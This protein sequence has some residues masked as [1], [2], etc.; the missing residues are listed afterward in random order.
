MRLFAT[1]TLATLLFLISFSALRAEE[2]FVFEP[3]A[4]ALAG[5]D[6]VRLV[7]RRFHWNAKFASDAWSL[8]F[9]ASEL[10]STI[11]EAHRLFEIAVGSQDHTFKSV[12]GE[13]TFWYTLPPPP[14]TATN[15]IG[16]QSIGQGLAPG[17][18]AGRGSPGTRG[19]EPLRR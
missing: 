1:G 10:D 8:I 7:E 6:G 17:C 11:E 4:L 15:N 14:A 19:G 5:T 13:S 12:C 2:T 3:S 18:G 9:S 16:V